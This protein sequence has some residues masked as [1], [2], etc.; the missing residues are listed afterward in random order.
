M[1]WSRLP[2]WKNHSIGCSSTDTSPP[3]C[4]MLSAGRRSF[5]FI[6]SCSLHFFVDSVG[7]KNLV[8]TGTGRF[9]RKWWTSTLS[10][11]YGPSFTF[12][13]LSKFPFPSRLMS[14]PLFQAQTIREFDERFTSLM[15]GYKSCSDYYFDASPDNKLHNT[16]VPILCLNA[17]DDPFSPQHGEWTTGGDAHG[18]WWSVSRVAVFW[19][20]F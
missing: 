11:R 12:P 3:A 6:N 14:S 10:W 15:F 4:V 18:F 13:F 17:A 7:K 16:A 19:F 20:Y 1:R 5:I 2:R 9:W 8:L